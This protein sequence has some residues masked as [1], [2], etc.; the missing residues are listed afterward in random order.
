MPKTA[1]TCRIKYLFFKKIHRK[2]GCLI[3][4]LGMSITLEDLLVVIWISSKHLFI[5][6]S[7]WRLQRLRFCAQQ[8]HQQLLLWAMLCLPDVMR[9]LSTR[10][11]IIYVILYVFKVYY[12]CMFFGSVIWCKKI[13]ISCNLSLKTYI[14]VHL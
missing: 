8:P 5:P 9:M 2:N 7:E 13:Q 11:L 14:N 12:K 3:P 6:K 4:W 1:K 10:K